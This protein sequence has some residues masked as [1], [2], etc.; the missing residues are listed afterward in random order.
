MLYSSWQ[1]WKLDKTEK[2]SDL[3]KATELINIEIESA[4]WPQS[5]RF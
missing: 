5:L 2:L 1:L 4:V 3:F